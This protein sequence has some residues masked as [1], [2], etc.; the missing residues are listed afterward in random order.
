MEVRGTWVVKRKINKI[1]SLSNHIKLIQK[2]KHENA[3]VVKK[4][5]CTYFKK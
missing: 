2:I 3:G 4:E 5:V 1:K